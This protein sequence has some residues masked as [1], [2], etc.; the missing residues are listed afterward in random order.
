MAAVGWTLFRQT[1]KQ[2]EWVKSVTGD[3]TKICPHELWIL[4]LHIPKTIQ[5]YITYI[6][7]EKK[8]SPKGKRSSSNTMQ[9]L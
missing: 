8:I 9:F 7:P 6:A 2:P 3:E 1:S 5:N 4:H